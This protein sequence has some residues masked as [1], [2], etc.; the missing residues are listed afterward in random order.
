M[1]SHFPLDELLKWYSDN[2]RD[3]PWRDISDPYK[4]WVSEIMLQQTRVDT[5]IPYYQRFLKELP[6]VHDLAK[7]DRRQVLK[8]WEGLGYYSRARNLHDAA[9]F[10]VKNS[11]GKIP[12]EFDAIIGLK[13]I[14][15]YTAAAILS[16]AFQKPH[17]V[18][19][20]NVIRVLSRF[21]GITNDIRSGATKNDIQ[22]IA[23]E[24][25]PDSA[26]GDFNQAVMELGATVC[27]PAD[28]KCEQC[29]LSCEC[30]AF[31][32][33][34]TD[35][36]PYKSPS[37]KIPHK[38]IGVGVILNNQKQV[39]IALRPEDSMLGGLWEFPGGKRKEN[40]QITD[41]ILRELS[42]ELGVKADIKHKFMTVK[43]TYSHFKITLN[44]YICTIVSG[45]PKPV[46]SQELKWVDMDEID[47][48]PFPKANKML[49]G[50][51]KTEYSK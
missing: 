23:D 50:K 13:G 29:P 26:P 41:T 20:G 18:V 22:R 39:L 30:F 17:A 40:E 8:L 36:I 37:K 6:T 32:T 33:L 10:V 11:K 47:E 15:P 24:I 21:F 25:I 51:L 35:Q 16:I 3:L 48:Y 19:D 27:I 34:Q 49:I 9:R 1:Y 7:A 5:V 4:I 42:E 31:K 14:G 2:K 45:N 12:E 44:A 43:H 28:P 38:E 46:C